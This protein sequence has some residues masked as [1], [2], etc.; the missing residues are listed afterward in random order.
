ESVHHISHR[1][2]RQRHPHVRVDRRQRFLGY[3]PSQYH[4]DRLSRSMTG[5]VFRFRC[6]LGLLLIGTALAAADEI[7][8]SERRSGYDTMSA[9]TR[10]MQ[11]DAPANPATLWV[12]EGETLWSSKPANGKS[13]ADCH[14]DAAQSMKGV[15]A[16]YPAFNTKLNKPIDLDQRINLCRAEHQNA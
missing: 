6:V 7:P 12:L 8:M 1:G 14:G 11:D 13:C 3:R 10:G 9:D 5:I 16:H 15:A 2:D 4:R